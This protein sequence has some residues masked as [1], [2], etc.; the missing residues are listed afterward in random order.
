MK[1]KYFY[2]FLI[3]CFINSNNNLFYFSQDRPAP[4]TQ[5]DIDQLE[6]RQ[7]KEGDAGKPWIAEYD[8]WD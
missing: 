1:S 4:A 3:T 7:L 5:S 2:H 6:K 8:F